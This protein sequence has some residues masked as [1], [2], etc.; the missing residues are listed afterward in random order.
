VIDRALGQTAAR[1]ET[2][3]SGTDDDGRDLFDGELRCDGRG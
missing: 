2:G 1:R 3:V